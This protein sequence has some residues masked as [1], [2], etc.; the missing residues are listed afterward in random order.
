MLDSIETEPIINITP[1][2]SASAFDN[3]ILDADTPSA[4]P[5]LMIQY[6]I[7]HVG[8][9]HSP[10]ALVAGLEKF[11]VLMT[12]TLIENEYEITYS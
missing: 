1:E 4:V 7:D 10:E 11:T 9:N 2:F 5:S 3:A 12:N 8:V 6:F